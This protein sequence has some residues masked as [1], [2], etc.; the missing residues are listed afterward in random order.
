MNYVITGD[1]GFIGAHLARYLINRSHSATVVDN[2]FSGKKEN[3]R[4]FFDNP[5]FYFVQESITDPGLLKS[6]IP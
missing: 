4:Y 5:R 6:R 1:A 3:L 2:L